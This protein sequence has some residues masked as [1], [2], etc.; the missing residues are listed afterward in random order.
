VSQFDPTPERPEVAARS[1]TFGTREPGDDFYCL[2]YS[3]WYPTIDCAFRT[4]HRTSGGCLN[5]DQGRFNLRR[6]AA[7]LR[8]SRWSGPRAD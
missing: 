2:R 1:A 5:C 8:G 4:L 3:V 7:A 6:H